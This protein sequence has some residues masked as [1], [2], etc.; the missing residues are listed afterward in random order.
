MVLLKQQRPLIKAYWGFATD[1]VKIF[2]TGG[3]TLG[4]AWPL[5]VAQL[6][7]AGMK[8]SQT[9]PQGRRD[10]LVGRLDAGQEPQEPALRA[11]PG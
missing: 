3:A 6:T 9:H 10:G 8:V 1:E 2:Q 4:A 7:R 5:A 11:R